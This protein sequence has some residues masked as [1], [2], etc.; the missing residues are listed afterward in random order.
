ME[1]KG[2]ISGKPVAAIV[3]AEGGGSDLMRDLSSGR[4]DLHPP[5]YAHSSK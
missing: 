5:P 4:E 2:E 1:T 3:N